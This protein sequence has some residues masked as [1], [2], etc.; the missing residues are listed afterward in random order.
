[1]RT[2]ERVRWFTTASAAAALLLALVP[3]ADGADGAQ[4]A[5]AER[6]IEPE[7]RDTLAE[8]APSDVVIEFAQPDGLAGELAAAAA[9]PDWTARG[10]AVADALRDAA[11]T[12]QADVVAELEARG[13]RY[14]SFWITNTIIVEGASE[15]LATV[16]AADGAVTGV[17]EPDT[18]ALEEPVAAAPV[19]TAAATGVEWGVANIRADQVWEQTRGEGV[20]VASID[21]GAQFDHPALVGSYRGNRHDGSFDHAYNWWDPSA[22]CGDP[23]T[24]PCDNVG[25]GSHTIGTMVGDDGAGN[26]IGVAPGATWISAKGCEFDGCSEFGLTSAAQWVLQPTDLDGRNPDSARR[27]DIVNN[28]WSGPAGDDWFR[29]IVRAWRAAGIFP[30]F[31]NG[32]TGPACGTAGAP[33]E[34]AEV[35]AVG[36]HNVNDRI[37]FDSSRGPGTGGDTKPDIS[38]PGTAVRSSVPGGGYA[39]YSGTSMAAPHVAGTVA[40]LWSAA[41][42]LAGDVDATRRLLDDGARDTDDTSC[43]GTA[44]DNNVYGEGR[45]DALAVIASAPTGDVGTLSGTV[46]DAATGAPVEGAELSVT[47]PASRGTATDASG[48]Y[49]LSLSAGSYDVTV[50]VFG[51]APV[52]LDGV[53]VTADATTVEDLALTPLERVA[54]SGVVTDGS[55][56]GWPLDARVDVDGTP[57]T[58]VTDPVTGAYELQVPVGAATL[59]VTPRYPGYVPE[60]TTLDLTAATTADVAVAVDTDTCTA[61]GYGRGSAGLHESFDDPETPAGWSL[62]DHAG[63]GQGWTFDDPGGH[64]NR[65][66]GSGGFAVL[67]SD[68]YGE[69]GEQDASLVTPAVDLTGVDRPVLEFRTDLQHYWFERGDVDVSLDGGTSWQNVY[70][71]R[72]DLRGPAVVRV[73]VPAAADRSGVLLRFHY[74]G[75]QHTWWWQVDD[76]YLGDS[77]CEPAPGG[78]VVG[79]VTSTH[80][81]SPVPG[82]EVAAGATAATTAEDGRYWLFAAAGR[83]R[84]TVSGGELAPSA[85]SVRVAAGAVTPYDVALGAGRLEATPAVV[86]ATAG[87]PGVVTATFTV[88]NTGD[89]PAS[90]RLE[91][92]DGAGFASAQTPPAD[93]VA[94]VDS[95]RRVPAEVSPLPG[96]ARPTQAGA[97][98]PRLDAAPW[99]DLAPYPTRVK[100]SVAGV[101]DGRLYSFG[102]SLG[103]GP[104]LR[105][106]YAYDE[107]AGSWTELAPLPMGRQ[108]PA[109]AFLGGR[110]VLSGGWGDDLQPVAATSIYDPATGSWSE[111]APNPSPWAASGTAVLDGQLYVVGGCAAETCGTTDVLRYDPVADA[112]TRLADYP[113]NT[114][115][116]SCGGIDGRVYCAGGI[117]PGGDSLSAYVYSPSEDEWTPV[118]DLP[119]DQWAAAYAV[120]DG[121][122]IVSG[123]AAERSSV[124]TNETHAYDPGT[125]TWTRLPASGYALYRTAGACGFVKVGGSDGVYYG[126]LAVERLPGYTDCAPSADLPW[127]RVV[128]PAGELKPGESRTVRVLLDGRRLAAGEYLASLRV[129][130]TTPYATPPV[131]VRLTVG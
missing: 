86:E 51:Y 13:V 69:D 54:V 126:D 121:R 6:K 5:T 106:A 60:T 82:A 2:H 100:D 112:W 44:D 89:R 10:E 83:Q 22:V 27:P 42:S 49:R 36:N 39:V 32:N 47:G 119:L 84:V 40:L 9:V 129:D 131:V 23:S 81:G 62:V 41:P 29:D 74:V 14:E 76:V 3:A 124:I 15:Q 17:R 85:R 125:D 24:A 28:S 52:R 34:Y 87:R 130:E 16:A 102:G 123:G 96:S 37:S 18:V 19:R 45:L 80:T 113:Q 71:Q 115:W 101:L 50:S 78:L 93:P 66:G 38:A 61:P 46:T 63:T 91:E 53:A 104:P 95:V 43:G 35:Y 94:A 98:G 122:L 12:S 67:D 110:F 120:V 99:V 30:V 108:K 103:D 68:A 48:A 73:P 92:R 20:V 25:H 55:G 7:L 117:G 70:R 107:A 77:G 33:G 26:R 109:G 75:G 114:A 116:T 57:L 88:T 1:M 58:T 59:T 72:A 105:T 127:L 21:S 118:A 111:G 64:G 11:R 65:T 31:S 90:F 97:G 79:T 4:M 56:A 8:G 128:S